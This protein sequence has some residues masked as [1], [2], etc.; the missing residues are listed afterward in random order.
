MIRV[1]LNGFIDEPARNRRL[2]IATQPNDSVSDMIADSPASSS[3]WSGSKAEGSKPHKPSG[4]LVSNSAGAAEVQSW[5]FVL[6]LVIVFVLSLRY[7]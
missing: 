7:S 3:Q 5:P 6:V 1:V 4:P 2:T